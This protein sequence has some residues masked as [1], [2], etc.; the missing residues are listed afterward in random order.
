MTKWR[1]GAD[2]YLLHSYNCE[3]IIILTRQYRRWWSVAE[4]SDVTDKYVG[5]GDVICP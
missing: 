2:T 1:N 5:G 4:S 3:Y